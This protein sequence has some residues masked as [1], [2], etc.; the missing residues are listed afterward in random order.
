MQKQ[1][2]NMVEV[3]S[4][5]AHIVIDLKY[6]SEDNFVGQRVYNFNTCYLLEEVVEKLKIVQTQLNQIDLG[7][8]IWDGYRPMY[9][10]EEFWRLMPDERYVA[11]PSKASRHTRGTAVDLT[12]IDL[13]TKKELEM[14][15]AFDDFSQAAHIDYTGASEIALNNRNLLIK[16]MEE[17]GFKVWLNEWWHFDLHDWQKYPV[18]DFIP[19]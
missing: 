18:L 8:K 3:T 2:N 12:L 17:H 16:I 15:S 14:P 10:Q 5:I 6:A 7:L 19:A 13:L 1:N 4:Q 11:H 9:A